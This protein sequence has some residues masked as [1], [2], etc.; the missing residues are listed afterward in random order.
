MCCNIR[1]FTTP[2]FKDNLRRYISLFNVGCEGLR[3]PREERSTRGREFLSLDIQ[4]DEE[5]G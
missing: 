5:W 2:F 3:V 1:L 4:R